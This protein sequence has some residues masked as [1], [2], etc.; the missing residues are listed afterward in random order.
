LGTVFAFADSIAAWL[1][2]LSGAR[3]LAVAV[4]LG[5]AGALAFEP[6]RI[7]PLLLLS[8]AGLTLLF[9]GAAAHRNRFRQAASIAW[10]YGFGFF[11]VGLY[12]VGYA[13]LVDP[14][15]HEWQIPF[16][17]V[18]APGL[19]ALFFALAAIICMLSWRRG[20]PRI[21]LFAFAFAL[22]EWLRGHVLTGFP[23]NLPAYGWGASTALL[24]S[25]SVFGAYGL[26]LLTLLL[27][28]SLAELAS[29]RE[30]ARSRW[31]PWCLCCSLSR[32][33]RTAK[34]GF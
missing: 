10:C 5:G 34:C 13:F 29:A 6:Y 32:C 21:F 16:V 25:A 7:F 15:A 2:Q 9:D 3:R 18:L 24:Q 28:A 11:L 14:G 1:I 33:G 27:G 26:S 22:V 4:A 23:W 17:A 31:L 8:Y 30:G 20:A 12:W 19:L